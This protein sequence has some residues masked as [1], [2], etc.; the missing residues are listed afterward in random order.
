M[1]ICRRRRLIRF[2]AQKALR[3]VEGRHRNCSLLLTLRSPTRVS[4]SS[5]KRVAAV[6][7]A[8]RIKMFTPP[9]H[10]DSVVR[11]QR[12]PHSMF[13]LRYHRRGVP[14]SP[15]YPS[16]R[17]PQLPRQRPGKA[18][19]SG[20]GRRTSAGALRQAKT[21][22]VNARTDRTNKVTSGVGC[23]SATSSRLSVRCHPTGLPHGIFVYF[24]NRRFK[25]YADLI[26]SCRCRDLGTF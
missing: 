12:N 15:R 26:K 8:V 6:A 5:P 16:G 10:K 7:A 14:S 25:T 1:S 2:S 3:A 23:L 24:L 19:T 17:I 21:F 20:D 9:P 22:P 18:N 11:T 13:P 4:W